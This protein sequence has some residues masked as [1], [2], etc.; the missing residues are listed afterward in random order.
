LRP[1]G[2]D[3]SPQGDVGMNKNGYNM[4]RCSVC[5]FRP[6]HRSGTANTLVFAHGKGIVVNEPS[7][8]AIN[9]ATG[10]VVAVGRE[11]KEMLGARRDVVAIKPNERRRHRRFQG[12]RK[13]ADLFIQKAHNRRV[14][15]I[16][17]SSSACRAKS[18]RWKNAPSGLAY[19]A[20]A[21]EVFLSSRPWPRDWR[22]AAD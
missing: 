20:R 9:K 10:E 15:G 18:L 3:P 22:R 1:D 7:I 17:E 6:R 14:L 8:V 21:S 5:F 19:R 13:D 16:R 4:S 11:A 2:G 12:H